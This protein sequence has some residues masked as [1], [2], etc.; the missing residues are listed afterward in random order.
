MYLQF[1]MVVA[2]GCVREAAFAR[3]AHASQITETAYTL[4][5]KL[6]RHSAPS[7]SWCCHLNFYCIKICCLFFA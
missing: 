3:P 4:C 7:L 1:Q 5:L 2:V 6:T